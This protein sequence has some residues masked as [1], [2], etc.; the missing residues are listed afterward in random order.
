MRA[1]TSGMEDDQLEQQLEYLGSHP[2]S[3]NTPSV[4]ILATLGLLS[5]LQLQ[6][7]NAYIHFAGP[8]IDTHVCTCCPIYSRRQGDRESCYRCSP[9]GS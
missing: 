9:G 1:E 2:V 7:L 3:L 6:Q 5:A 4:E 8:L